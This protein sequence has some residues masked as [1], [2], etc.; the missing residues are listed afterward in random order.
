[1]SPAVYQIKD[2]LQA[3]T[4]RWMIAGGWAIDLFL[5]KQTRAHSDIEIAIPRKEQLQLQSY[6]EGWNFSYYH[7]GIPANWE[8]GQFLELPLHE[9]HGK[10]GAQNIE[11]L[12]NEIEGD[13]WH[14]RRKLDITWPVD[15]LICHHPDGIPF[16]CPEVVLLYK[17]KDPRKKDFLDVENCLPDLSKESRSYL[18]I[19]ISDTHDAS[20]PW[21]K[22][23]NL[24][25]ES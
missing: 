24:L 7:K 23:I 9:I 3:Y 16:L 5:N 19:S 12:L 1:M 4:G 11:I 21:V 15:K 6:L 10:K 17:A 13:T 20:H 2:L 8:E 14:F 18:K 25:E 22:E